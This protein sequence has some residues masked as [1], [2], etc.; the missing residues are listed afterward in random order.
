MALTGIKNFIPIDE[1]LATGGQPT[2][3]QLADVAAAGFGAVINLGL[4]DPG[5]CLRDEEGLAASLG[6]RYRQ[7]PVSFDAPTMDDLRTFIEVMDGLADR[8]VFVHCAANYRV[9]VFMALWGQLRLGWT[10]ERADRLIERLWRP[11]S[12]WGEFLQRAR[13]ELFA[14]P[15]FSTAAAKFAA[16]LER[17]GWPRKVVWVRPADLQLG[18][19][20]V[21]I[22]RSADER[23]DDAAWDYEVVRASG[24]GVALTAV[25][26]LGEATC[27]T[28][29]A[30]KDGH[31][32]MIVPEKRV[33]G[34]ERPV[35]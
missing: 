13:E 17:A 8:R 35:R 22:A 11:S 32:T 6:L 4:L 9:S 30:A 27:A 12:V 1:R 28:I 7:I 20:P 23:D 29:G 10:P 3:A 25:C 21:V 16:H 2:E 14:S 5:Y 19:A 26:V 18:D 33:A 31:L 24:S 34:T 15:P